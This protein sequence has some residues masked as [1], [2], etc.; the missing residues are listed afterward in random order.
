MENTLRAGLPALGASLTEEQ[1]QTLLAFGKALLEKN[2]VMNL[3]A[4][5]EPDKVATLHFLDSL[6]L[7]GA[8]ELA[9][10]SVVDV[11]CGAGFPGVP[12][13]IAEPSIRL[14]LLDS[15]GKR[16]AWLRETLPALGVEAET[17]TARA[18]DYAAEKRGGFDVCVSRAVARM[19]VLAELCLPLVKVGGRFL[20]MKGATAD[21]ELREAERAIETLGG[22]ALAVKRFPIGDAQHAVIVIEKVRPTPKTYPRAYAKIKKNPL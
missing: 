9:G 4:I 21:E 22:K 13:K 3:T 10:K 6:T 11:G 17:V 20:A 15:L 8:E 14:T 7:L 16:V 18:E 12:L 5:R 1:I 2:Q 19:N